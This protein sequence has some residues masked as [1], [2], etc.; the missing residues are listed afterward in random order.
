MIIE[1]AEYNTKLIAIF[2]KWY[3]IEMPLI[4]LGQIQKYLTTISKIFSFS[5]LL[6]TFFSPWKNQLYAYPSKGFDLK[7]IFEVWTSNMVSRVVGAMVR[8]F[9]IL[10]GFLILI[11]CLFLGVGVLLVWVIYPVLFFVLIILSFV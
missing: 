8:G 4:I 9:T 3:W 6:K 7:R 5:F 1:T 10:F 2:I 11:F